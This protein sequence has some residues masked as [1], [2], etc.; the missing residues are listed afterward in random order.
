MEGD[1]DNMIL[2]KVFKYTE[3]T[4]QSWSVSVSEH[5]TGP[6]YL[7]FFCSLFMVVSETHK[8]YITMICGLYIEDAQS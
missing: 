4:I 5:G 1:C 8:S 2:K 3:F 7:K 6:F